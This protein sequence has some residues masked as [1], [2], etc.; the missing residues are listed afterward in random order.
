MK[1]VG[2]QGP[3]LI[4]TPGGEKIMTNADSMAFLEKYRIPA[5]PSV[6]HLLEGTGVRLASS[7][8]KDMVEAISSLRKDLK[9]LKQVNVSID[10]KGYRLSISKNNSRTEYL[11][12]KAE[13]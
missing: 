3:E 10:E 7:S 13:L 5:M 8:N 2:E 12:R 1:W 9:N 6:D 4:Y 11:N